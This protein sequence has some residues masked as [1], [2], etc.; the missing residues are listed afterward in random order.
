MPIMDDA[1]RF[2]RL[3]VVPNRPLALLA[4]AAARAVI[5]GKADPG[6]AKQVYLAYFDAVVVRS[7]TQRAD[8]RKVQVSKLRQIM[9]LA[10]EQPD[11]VLKLLARVSKL[12]AETIR[13]R[14][15]QGLFASMVDAAREQ[16]K[17]RKQLTNSQLVDVIT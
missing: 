1:K 13:Y 16:L 3:V 14:K 2:G 11:A 12:H 7:K 17:S 10:A 9:L 8:S 4:E 5:A 15:V 6:Q